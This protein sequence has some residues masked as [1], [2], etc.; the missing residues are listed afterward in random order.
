MLTFAY[1]ARD[2]LGHVLE[3]T[4][5]V[6]SR[7]EALA[8]LKRDGLAVIALD[9][10]SVGFDLL[11]RRIKQADII[12]ATSQLAVMVDTGITL[13]TALDSIAQQEA[14][15]ALKQVLTELKSFVDRARIFR[16]GPLSAAFR[17]TLVALIKA[18]EQTGT[19]GEISETSR[20]TS[21]A[22]LKRG[23]R[24]AEQW[25]TVHHGRARDWRNGVSARSSCRSSTTLSR[26]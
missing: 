5:E 15:P 19:L 13:S 16:R 4:L 22:S 21:A 23:R 25:P 2:P 8:R 26:R 12:Y 20:I 14:N 11:T 3:G 9:E 6:G 18:S 10:E 1:E 7:D 17:W 24:S